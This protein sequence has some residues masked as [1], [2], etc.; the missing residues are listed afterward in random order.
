LASG[1]GTLAYAVLEALNLFVKTP[2]NIIHVIFTERPG[3]PGH[4]PH[5]LSAPESL[6]E[7]WLYLLFFYQTCARNR[8]L[9]YVA[10]S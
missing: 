2:S 1:G 7:P 3:L 9:I 6:L 8:F 5:L 4:N 10:S